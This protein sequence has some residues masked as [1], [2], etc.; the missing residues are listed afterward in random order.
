MR[1][2]LSPNKYKLSESK[3][4]LNDTSL[5]TV[6]EAGDC[7]RTQGVVQ[8][9]TVKRLRIVHIGC[10]FSILTTVSSLYCPSL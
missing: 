9:K 10:P 7:R 2:K 3:Q 5:F 1:E 4:S 8:C 6:Q